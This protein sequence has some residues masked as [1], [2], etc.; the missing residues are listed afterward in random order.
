MLCLQSLKFSINF[1]INLSAQGGN[2]ESDLII[3]KYL[4]KS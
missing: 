1:W 2:T 3:Y 4:K